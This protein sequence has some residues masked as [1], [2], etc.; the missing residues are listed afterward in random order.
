MPSITRDTPHQHDEVRRVSCRVEDDGQSFDDNSYDVNLTQQAQYMHDKFEEH[1][2]WHHD[3]RQYQE[4]Q[5]NTGPCAAKLYCPRFELYTTADNG[6]DPVTV[7]FMPLLFLSLLRNDR[8][9][10]GSGYPGLEAG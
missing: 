4:T 5:A 1:L 10:R 6:D 9:T 7:T 2:Q 3:Q 8:D